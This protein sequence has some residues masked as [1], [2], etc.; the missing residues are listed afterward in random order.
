MWTEDEAG[1]YQTR[2]IPGHGWH[3]VGEPAH[4]PHEYVRNGTA[5]LLTLFHPHTGAVRVTGVT[6]RTNAVLHPWLREQLSAILAALPVPAL[7]RSQTETRAVWERWQ[8]GLRTRIT[9]PDDLPPLRMRLVLDNLTGHYTPD[10]VRWLFAHGI[11]PL[12]TPLGGR[13]LHLAASIQRIRKR[14]ARDGQ[15]PQSA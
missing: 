9:L 15:Y 3:P 6:H 10:F 11:L 7:G 1:P 5:K 4:Y 13:W 14:R 12:Y 2:P 8:E